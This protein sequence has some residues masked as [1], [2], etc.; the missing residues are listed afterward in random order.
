M[1]ELLPY[2][3]WAG[4]TSRNG[5]P[6]D[7]LVSMLQISIRRAEEKNALI[8]AYEMHI[9]SPQ[10]S[11]K[12]WRRLLS[13]SVEDIGFGDPHA[14]EL[15]W[16]LYKMRREF[17]YPGGDQTILFVYAIRYLCRCRKE[18]TSENLKNMLIKKFERGYVPQAPDYAFDMHTVKGCEMGRDD[19]HFLQEASLV[20]PEVDL[21]WVRRLHDEYIDFC[22]KERATSGKPLVQA[23]LDS[24]WR[25]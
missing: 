19:I 11:D 8:A 25:D 6:G 16:S 5:I 21:P 2:D 14:P 24:R 15:I 4:V 12:M 3:P 20:I 17:P 22:K 10:L 18:R 23:F 13:I 1:S 9:T 7:E